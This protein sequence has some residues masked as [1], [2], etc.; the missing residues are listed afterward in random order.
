M[1]TSIQSA[2][3]APEVNLRITQA[4]NHTRDPPWLW[5]PGQ[6]SPEVQNR[7]ISAPRKGLM[8]SNFFSKKTIL[9]LNDR[10][11]KSS[12]VN[13]RGIPTAAY[14]VLLKMGYPPPHR[15][16]PL[17]RSDRGGVPE[18]GFPSARSDGEGY[19]RWG[20][21]IGV[22]PSQGTPRPD[23]TGRYLGWGTPCE[24]TPQLDLAGVPSPPPPGV[25]RQMDGSTYRHMSK[26]NLPSYYVR[27]R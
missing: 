4:R 18:V 13:A 22:P 1:L 23:P 6:T 16:I 2:G 27:G 14:Q 12:C 8:P 19:P 10:A 21:P 5:N 26:H 24:G 20:T 15:G 17:T 11:R 3:V 9:F 7:G 25:E